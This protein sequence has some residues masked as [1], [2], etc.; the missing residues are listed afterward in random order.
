[1]PT[2]PR[3]TWRVSEKSVAAVTTSASFP[4]LIASVAPVTMSAS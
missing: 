4:D 3:K 2:P 1:M